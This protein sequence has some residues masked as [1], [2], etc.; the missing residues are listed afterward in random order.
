MKI[1]INLSLIKHVIMTFLRV[2]ISDI[3]IAWICTLTLY[4]MSRKFPKTVTNLHVPQRKMRKRERGNNRAVRGRTNILPWYH[5][6][7]H[8][9][10]VARPRL[11][12]Y[13]FQE[14]KK[15]KKKK[16]PEHLTHPTAWQNKTSDGKLV[17]PS[18]TFVMPFPVS[19][20]T[21]LSQY[22]KCHFA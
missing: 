1:Q 16:K 2:C 9:V 18:C 10:C 11:I 8:S 5:I 22:C 3:I 4:S 6:W 21:L 7:I 15:K 13:L 14:G 19:Y 17:I 20:L 12:S